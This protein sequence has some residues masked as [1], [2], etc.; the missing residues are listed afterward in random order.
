[1]ILAFENYRTWKTMMDVSEEDQDTGLW[2]ELQRAERLANQGDTA[3]A[4]M[5]LTQVRE[6]APSGM[7]NV[8][9]SQ[10]MSD[11]YIR[12]GNIADAYRVLIPLKGKIAPNYL[13]SLHSYAYESQHYQ[14]AIAVGNQLF[15]NNP[16]YKTALLNALC[17]AR[18][19]DVRPS[20]GWLQ[21]AISEGLPN[22]RAIMT[23][24][25]FRGISNDPQFRDFISSL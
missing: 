2:E 12:Q 19:G 6:A 22:P 16:N 25:D 13:E 23:K 8:Q 20:I 18:L 7:V 11:L 15:E 14:E 10:L 21:S 1:M 5:I 4:M 9:A 17:H 3:E 24:E